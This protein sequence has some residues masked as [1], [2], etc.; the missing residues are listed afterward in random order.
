MALSLQRPIKAIVTLRKGV[1]YLPAIGA[2]KVGWANQIEFG[3]DPV[4]A[5]QYEVEGDAIGPAHGVADDGWP[6]GPIHPCAL[7]SGV[8]AP[9]R[10]KHPSKRR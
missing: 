7:N 3:I 1:M 2:I 5:V 10:P 4:D 6:V 8:F 9:I